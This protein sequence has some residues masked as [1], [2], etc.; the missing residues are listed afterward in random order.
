MVGVRDPA[1]F[2]DLGS[3]ECHYTNGTQQMRYPDKIIWDRQEIC[4]YDSGVGFYMVLIEMGWA[5][6]EYWNRLQWLSYLWASREKYCS[7]NWRRTQSEEMAEV[8]YKDFFLNGGC[9]FRILVTLE[10]TPKQGNVYACQVEPVSLPVPI[11]VAWKKRLE[12]RRSE[13]LEESHF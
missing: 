5:I 4:S 7:Y 2:W 10:V 13:S 12:M 1:A 6:A 3:A 9:F 8:V 11:T